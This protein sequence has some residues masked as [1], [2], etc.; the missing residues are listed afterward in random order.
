VQPACR[1]PQG[2]AGDLGVE[3][4]GTTSAKNSDGQKVATAYCPQGKIAISG[5]AEVTGPTDGLSGDSIAINDIDVFNSAS[6]G[7]GATVAALEVGGGTTNDW[8]LI[9]TVVCIAAAG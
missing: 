2:I 8:S 1:G 4:K 5:G 3:K 6:A 7:S 9:A